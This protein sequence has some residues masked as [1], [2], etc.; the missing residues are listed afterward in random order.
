MPEQIAA[1]HHEYEL[2]AR[3]HPMLREVGIS[4]LAGTDAGY[5]NAFDYPGESSTTS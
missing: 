1:R 3:A 5:L 2:S 4:I